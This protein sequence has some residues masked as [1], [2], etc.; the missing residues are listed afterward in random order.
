MSDPA[1]KRAR[2]SVFI[3]ISA[4][5]YTR[6][7]AGVPLPW[8]LVAT[9][10]L[11]AA[12]IVS[13][14]SAP[15]GASHAELADAWLNDAV[16]T[17]HNLDAFA[18]YGAAPLSV[19]LG[20]FLLV[21]PPFAELNPASVVSYMAGG[22]LLLTAAIGVWT[23]SDPAE[24]QRWYAR[25]ASLGLVSTGVGLMISAASDDFDSGQNTLARRF[26]F[27][28]G[29]VDAGLFLSLFLLNVLM[30]PESPLAVQLSLR[31]SDPGQ[32]H[33]RVLEFLK[34][35]SKQQRFAM[36]VTTPWS[37]ALGVSS[38]AFSPEAATSGGRAF[39][40]GLGIGVIALSAFSVIYEL[41]RTPDW[42]RFEAGEGP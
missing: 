21:A 5:G 28:A 1:P 18:R 35:R 12:P 3:A 15:A 10:W 26:S 33:A 14:Q 36:F 38:I 42:E 16:R 37:L 29:A 17:Q 6:F 23:A 13:A 40:L 20:G 4:D 24:A 19:A 30:P 11:A 27:A 39:M 41:A 2:C 34:L 9:L 7:L 31:G 25:W 22:A 32:R 8:V